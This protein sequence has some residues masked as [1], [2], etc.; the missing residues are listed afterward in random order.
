M[1]KQTIRSGR[2]APP[3]GAYSQG[4]RAGDFIFVTGTVPV[5]P[6]GSVTGDTIG[7]QTNLTIDNVEAVLEAGGATLADVVKVNVYLHEVA[8]FPLFNEAYKERFSE[9]YP[10][11]TTVGSDLAHLPLALIEMDCV[12][13]VGD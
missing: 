9:P 7:E 8:L 5:G 12:A 3:L 2:G 6:D 4:W 11:R 1:P 13:Y 10:V